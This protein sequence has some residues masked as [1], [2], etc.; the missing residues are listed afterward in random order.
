VY[1]LRAGGE[2]TE[3][4]ADYTTET[5]DAL[6]MLG[7]G[8][9]QPAA[10]LEPARNANSLTKAGLVLRRIWGWVKISANFIAH[11]KIL[12]GAKLS[13]WLCIALSIDETGKCNLTIKELAEIAGYSH[14][15]V[16]DSLK[17]LQVMGYLGI[18]KSGKKNIYTP[19]FAA[20]A[21]KK[22]SKERLVKK[23][24]STPVDQ[25]ESSPSEENPVPSY[26][27]LKELKKPLALTDLENQ[28]VKAEA[29][30]KVDAVLE[31]ERKAQQAKADGKAWRGREF[32]QPEHY[33][34][35]DWWHATT[36]LEMYGKKASPKQDNEWLKALKACWENELT[37]TELAEA[38]TVETWEGKRKLSKLSQ[39]IGTAKA[40]HAAGSPAEQTTR[41]QGKGFYA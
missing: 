25:Y 30:K 12:K 6:E 31:F 24:E 2:M 27:E 8:Y 11:I 36:G 21:D 22:P 9:E 5:E 39:V 7:A 10:I 3:P 17:E 1:T 37:I 20:R 33:I 41:E 16:I 4:Q 14:T 15:E 29:N 23:L 32:V 19:E 35:A 26:R 13:I 38:Y 40:I 34:Y 18:D 28:Q